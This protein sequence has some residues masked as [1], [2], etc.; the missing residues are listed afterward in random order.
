[1]TE[2][3]LLLAFEK[4]GRGASLTGIFLFMFLLPTFIMIMINI[5]KGLLPQ[6]AAVPPEVNFDYLPEIETSSS[7]Q[8][9]FAEEPQHKNRTREE[10]WQVIADATMEKAM[11]GDKAAR[12]WVTKHIFT[13]PV[14]PTASSSPF[15]KDAVDA[16][17]GIGY[18]SSEVKKLALE[19]SEQK[20]YS[21][22]DELIQD[23]IK[24]C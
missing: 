5:F 22:L 21:S 9:T 4:S 13:D 8:I 1:M 7:V 14:E 12:D 6:P 11:Q 2:S 16:L 18:K 24:N 19:L 17:K 23:I 3:L 20:E 15:I 10:Q